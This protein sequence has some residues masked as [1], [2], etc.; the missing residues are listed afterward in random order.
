MT[1][2]TYVRTVKALNAKGQCAQVEAALAR[3]GGRG[4]VEQIAAEL[5]NDATFRT[6]QTPERIAAYYVCVMKKSGHV[7]AVDT[8]AAPTPEQLR[9]ERDRLAARIDEIT[10]VLEAEFEAEGLA[11]DLSA[12]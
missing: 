1:A 10:A 4:T 12:E 6:V 3:L 11:A 7:A 5:A 2:A 8:A 9:A